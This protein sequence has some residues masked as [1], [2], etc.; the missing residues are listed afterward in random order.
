[1][2]ARQQ[3]RDRAEPRFA[4]PKEAA[5]AAEHMATSHLECRDHG[6]PWKPWSV[7]WLPADQSY[8]RIF[9][10]TRC[11]TKRK[12]LVD[13]SGAILHGG[14]EYPDGYLL[15]IGRLAGGAKDALRLA[16]LQRQLVRVG[17]KVEDE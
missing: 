1:M 13:S 2:V 4:D 17:S 16:S 10:C 5:E 11:K 3:Q 15:D 9:R 12:Q 7:R 6:H 14:Y 8:E